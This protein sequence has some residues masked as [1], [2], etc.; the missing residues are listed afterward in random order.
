MAKILRVSG[1]AVPVLVGG[2]SHRPNS[3]GEVERA[4]D[5]TIL[6]S[7]RIIKE[8]YKIQVVHQSPADGI[9]WKKLFTGEGQ[10]WDFDTSVYGSK[11]LGPS[12][13][14]ASV[15]S[16]AAAKFG[17]GCCRQ[18]ATTGTI[19]YAALPAGGTKWTVMFW[20]SVGGAAFDHYV[21][22]SSGHKWLNGVRADGTSTTFL[23]VTTA[24]GTVKLDAAGS[25]TD[26]D[27]LVILPFEVPDLWPPDI[28]A[29]GAAFSKLAKLDVD[30]DLIDANV[31]TK[32]VAGEVTGV[33]VV[34]GTLNGTF[35]PSLRVVEV[36]L[37]EG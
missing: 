2:A 24:T 33:S 16:G 15:Q 14:T 32:S 28:F 7:R 26:L 23:T 35:Y 4:E 22:T 17:T 21:V 8:T 27:D 12:A 19:S 25:T 13:A 29:Y 18:T 37:Q 5:G 6:I 34:P 30:G 11:G 36:E 3:I 20:R 10:K 9:A 1:I 31:G